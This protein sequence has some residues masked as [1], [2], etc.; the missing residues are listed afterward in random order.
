MVGGTL[1]SRILVVDDDED[2]LQIIA[3]VLTQAGFTV[4][5]ARTGRDAVEIL[6]GEKFD[7]VVTDVVLPEYLSGVELVRYARGRRPALKSLFI[8]DHGGP[9]IDH[10]HQDDFVQKPFHDWELLGCVFELLNRPVRKIQYHSPRRA[11]ELA[12]A[13]A[14]VASL[15]KTGEGGVTG[16]ILVVD[17]DPDVLDVAAMMIEELELPVLRAGGGAEALDLLD[18][19]PNIVLLVTDI[20]M[21][22]MDGW[23]LARIAKQ[24]SP[25]LKVLYTSGYIKNRAALPSEEYGP[26]L[27]KPWRTQQLYD[28]VNRVLVAG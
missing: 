13:A 4:S 18:A 25:D 19:N 23:E 7:L 12:K 15:K 16:A 11:A 6:E 9:V 21:P 14:K 2:I 8:A 5:I 10:P 28:A 22:G 27:P 1:R 24:R 26:V 3:K 20:V 17:D